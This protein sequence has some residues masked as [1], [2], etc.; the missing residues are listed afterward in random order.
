MNRVFQHL[1]ALICLALVG[2]AIAQGENPPADPASEPARIAGLCLRYQEQVR[3]LQ[4]DL[5]EAVRPSTQRLQAVAQALRVLGESGPA[6]ANQARAL[7]DQAREIRSRMEHYEN[8][9]RGESRPEDDALSRDQVRIALDN[10]R[11]ELDRVQLLAQAH[12]T[13]DPW[14]R[15]R[16]Q[17]EMALEKLE[18]EQLIETRRQPYRD[19]IDRLR[20]QATSFSAMLDRAMQPFGRQVS[21]GELETEAVR[22]TSRFEHGLIQFRWLDRRGQ[23]VASAQVNLRAQPDTDQV[24]PLLAER[25]PILQQ[26]P[27]EVTVGVGYFEIR[28]RADAQDLMGERKVLD[29]VQRLLDLDAL[30]RLVPQ[31]GQDS[32]N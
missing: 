5:E 27:Q 20:D 19:Q 26:N 23:L 6:D 11:H 8:L 21:V 18:L 13:A 31:V 30:G 3:H 22:V 10:L 17:G 24:P 29:A 1:V 25:Y 2:P 15:Q 7:Q 12:T 16:L 4:N 28:F 14:D 9:L 32:T